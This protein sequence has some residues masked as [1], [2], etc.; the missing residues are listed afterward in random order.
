MPNKINITGTAG[1][2]YNLDEI[3]DS[4]SRDN[5]SEGLVVQVWKWN[6]NL[7]SPYNSPNPPNPVIGQI[8]LSKLVK[9]NSADYKELMAKDGD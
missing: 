9:T 6:P 4:G 8:W 2:T 5:P 7:Q 3:K 1:K